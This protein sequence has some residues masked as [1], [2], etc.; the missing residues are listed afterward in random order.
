LKEV[1][2]PVTFNPE[3]VRVLGEQLV[4]DPLTALSEL[5]K[6][7]YDA[8]AEKVTIRFPRNRKTIVIQ[9]DGNGM[10][11]DEI[12]KGWLEI[13]TGLKRRLRHPRS[14]RKRRILV[15]SMGIGRLAAF[16]L[17]NIIDTQTGQQ[18]STWRSFAL[19]F[20][21]IAKAKKLSSILVHI[22]T[23]KGRPAKQGTV[24]T[25]RSL[26]W[27]P[28]DFQQVKLRLSAL[29]SP[30]DVTDF[31]I[32]VEYEGKT[33][34]IEPEEDLPSSPLVL[35]SAVDSKGKAITT[36]RAN[37]PLYEGTLPNTQWAFRHEG[38]VYPALRDVKLKAFWYALGERPGR[39]YWRTTLEIQRIT[40]ETSGVRVY[41]NSI[42]VLPYGEPGDDW[43][44]LEKHYTALGAM[45]RSPRPMQ[46]IGWVK[47]SREKNPSLIDVA[48]RQGLLNNA[49]FKQLKKF[50]QT[51]F[52]FLASARREIEPLV[53]RTHELSPE[54][55]PEVEKAVEIIRNAISGNP[56]LKER[57]S[58]IEKAISAFYEQS[59][60]TALYR[61]R[62]TA[63]LLT[64]I[65]MHDIGVPLNSATP[66]L[67]TAAAEGCDNANHKRAL[68]FI[69]GMV[70]KINEGYVLLAGGM[71]PD[72]YKIRSLNVNEVIGA[73][74]GQIKTVAQ[75]EKVDI[76]FEPGESIRARVRR[77]DLWAIVTNLVANA[78]QAAGYT[79]ARG[80]DFPQERKIVVRIQKSKDDLVIECEDNGPGLPDK[81]EE[82]IWEAY[83]TTKPNGS[84]LGLYIVSDIVAWYSGT[85]TAQPSTRFK[86]G[87]LFHATLR[88][89]VV[90]A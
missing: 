63:G 17:A 85:K 7:A 53:P 11:L 58:L 51:A 64:S 69:A 2:A 47:I 23:I 16:S 38:E 41:R 37:A 71:Q 59:E 87:A 14:K 60:L 83:N 68:R 18:S 76:Q 15:G 27:W 62:L 48:N 75:S 81:P 39:R 56:A 42:R 3:T 40:K 80:R 21:R 19:D 70:P 26:K 9:D 82:W 88:G 46:I 4:S 67:M 72:A 44:E 66:N 1:V 5:V 20:K 24:I 8:D 31:E 29:S 12:V 77:S 55:K 36:I 52:E 74:V 57:F 90:N 32:Y 35:E 73:T 22:N 34:R 54:D 28:S 65:V 50:C 61:D 84:G 13:G 33:E 49:D 30:R 78:I 45:S 25:L 86:T 89:V 43:L 6:N 79:H 10:S